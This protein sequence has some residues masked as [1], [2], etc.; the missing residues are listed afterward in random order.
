MTTRRLRRDFRP[1]LEVSEARV[2]LSGGRFEHAMF[3]RGWGHHA[4]VHRHGHWA[5]HGHAGHVSPPASA[6]SS[7]AQTAAA[8]PA[9]P[10]VS[11]VSP[12]IAWYS[13]ASI[14]YG[15]PLGPDQLDASANVPGV[16][17]YSP[18]PGTILGAGAHTL[19]VTFTPEDTAD[20]TS[21]SAQVVLQVSKAVPAVSWPTPA[22][23][24]DGTPLNNAQLNG[25]ANVPGTFSYSSY[26]VGTVLSPGT[27]SLTVLFTPSDSADY[28]TLDHF[29]TLTVVP[30]VGYAL[31][32]GNLYQYTDGQAELLATGVV[33][34][35]VT[36]DNSVVYLE[37]T[38][39]LF[40]KPS[41][42]QTQL[43]DRLAFRFSIGPNNQIDVADWFN[44]SLSDPGVTNLAR[45]DFTRDDSLT[46]SDM[47]GIFNDALQFGEPTTAQWH[48]IQTLVSSPVALNMPAYVQNLA[49][50]VLDPTQADVSYLD[51]YYANA[52]SMTLVQALVNQWF[53]G[54]VLPDA[55]DADIPTSQGNVAFDPTNTYSSPGAT[56]DTLFGPSGPDFWTVSQ[57]SAGDCWL[58]AG[59]A[60]TA[61][62]DPVAIESMFISNGNG[63]WTVRLYAN[64][65]P[66]YV[67]VN[68]QLPL[69]T[70]A[71]GYNGGYAFD[72][73]VDGELWAALAEKAF[74]EENLGGQITTSNQG[75]DSYAALNDG[76]ASWSLNAI[77]GWSSA[78]YGVTPGETSQQIEAAL[79]AGDL[80]C[81][82]TP[83]NESNQNLAPDHCY[84]VVGYN[85]ALSD[86]FELYNPW[87]LTNSNLAGVY[88]Y[89]GANAPAIDNLFGEWDIA[90]SAAPGSTGRSAVAGNTAAGGSN[91]GRAQVVVNSGEVAIGA[92][93]RAS[94]GPAAS[95]HAT[96]PPI[97]LSAPPGPAATGALS[98]G[99][100][101]QSRHDAFD[102]AL[103]ELVN[104]GP[105]RTFSA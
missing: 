12:A 63:T 27:Q 1:T 42:G 44:S 86:P 35:G 33:E 74:A 30:S 19:T 7:F 53:L 76:Y 89:F 93:F 41:S 92:R 26:P 10:P 65:R 17:T 101:A 31:T 20:Y 55:V 16:M 36:S 51:W 18:A 3:H 2:L 4:E 97:R 60:E 8:P 94:T 69:A 96:R 43:L 48:D 14:V 99:Q 11:P 13:P 62:R 25:A 59:L 9:A 32:E 79:Q 61:A 64:G 49:S 56:G 105:P 46:Y 28:M 6:P 37:Q 73:P 68:D 95:I 84:A 77:T 5:R 71:N 75:V 91:L 83:S 72:Q 98:R 102:L 40:E 104:Q 103:G 100:A 21:A 45:E 70:A 78:T 82:D 50:K 29:V 80:I 52:P 67:T 90:T 66:D 23:I 81:I 54:T 38:G 57:G 22:P 39:D 47:L 88:G 15:T 24:P 87:G 85:P 34:Y 58:L